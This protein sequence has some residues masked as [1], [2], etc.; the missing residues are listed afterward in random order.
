MKV[1]HGVL[2]SAREVKPTYELYL[3]PFMVFD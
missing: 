1:A 2:L 3:L